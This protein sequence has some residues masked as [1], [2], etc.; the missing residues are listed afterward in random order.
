ML[1][2]YK[3]KQINKKLINVFKTSCKKVKC[4]TTVKQCLLYLLHESRM[5]GLNI[6]KL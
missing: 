4:E 2:V 1:F 6:I 5:L 3:R